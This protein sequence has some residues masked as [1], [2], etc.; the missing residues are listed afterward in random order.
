MQRTTT[1]GSALVCILVVGVDAQRRPVTPEQLV[2][3]KEQKLEEAFLKNG[4]W[5]LSFADAKKRAKAEG[6]LI[7]GYFTRSYSP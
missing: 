5:T 3:R 6:K 2:E 7:F 4:D 1:L